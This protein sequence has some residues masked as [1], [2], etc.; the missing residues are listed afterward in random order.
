MQTLN[1]SVFIGNFRPD[2]AFLTTKY[3]FEDDRMFT[4]L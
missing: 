1:G 4:N 3:S 2:P